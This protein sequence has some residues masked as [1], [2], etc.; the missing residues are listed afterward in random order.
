LVLASHNEDIQ[1][2][3]CLINFEQTTYEEVQ[4][5]HPKKFLVASEE[6]K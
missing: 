6:Q 2:F 4:I 1:S 3:E 5:L